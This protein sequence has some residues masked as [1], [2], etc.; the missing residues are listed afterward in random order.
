[1]A[2]QASADVFAVS[3]ELIQL[4]EHPYAKRRGQGY[5]QPP[6]IGLRWKRAGALLD[7]QNWENWTVRQTRL[8]VLGTPDGSALT[9][10]RTSKRALMHGCRPTVR[11]LAAT[12]GLSRST[13]SNALRD[14]PGVNPETR[15]RVRQVA[16]RMGY[17]THPFATRVMSQLRRSSA[18]KRVGT[19]A[20]LELNEPGRPSGAA[21][22]NRYLLEGIHER[23]TA[24][25]FAIAHWNF[26]CG[27]EVS[28]R[29]LDQILRTRGIQGLMLLPTWN[30]P[31]FTELDWSRYTGIY[32]DY[33][34]QR[35]SLH[36]V[37]SDHFRTLVDALDKARTLG[38]QK[39][40]FA[41][42]QQANDRLNGRWMGAYL[43]Y[44][45]A[46]SELQ[47][48]PPLFAEEIRAENF[49]TWFCE[50][51]PDVVISHWVGAPE[52]MIAV[53]ADVPGQHGYICLNLAPAPSHFSGYNLQPE[54][55]GARATEM[56][57]SQLETQG[58]GVPSVASTSLVPARWVEG[59]TTHDCRSLLPN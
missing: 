18:E 20:V 57:I 54:L 46:H 4:S 50:H 40:G 11:T 35:P 56:L 13:V 58:F 22:Y 39:I 6:R 43:S 55:L 29:R 42:A 17:S 53:G 5:L 23:A 59:A 19:L 21:I 48:V 44:L 34:I 33:A 45:H 27:G 3:S 38:Y 10:H 14:C 52:Q 28:L 9:C 37:S 31:D 12:L 15:Q 32:L 7:W 8:K 16:A 49:R 25:G 47:T 24:M 36:T 26:G 41:L 30:E 51:R 1:M 2:I